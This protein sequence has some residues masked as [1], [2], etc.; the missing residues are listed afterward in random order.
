MPETVIELDPTPVWS[1][2]AM[3]RAIDRL[4]EIG[5]AA[6]MPAKHLVADLARL[7]T[8]IEEAK[9]KLRACLADW[10][11]KELRESGLWLWPDFAEPNDSPAV[12]S[13][14]IRI[15][16][17]PHGYQIDCQA[18]Y[19]GEAAFGTECRDYGGN[20]ESIEEAVH[21]I[22]DAVRGLA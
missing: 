9:G 4:P 13:A 8:E 10:S 6:R 15:G 16:L 5:P 22:L 18:D 12:D 7:T 1:L 14:T 20:I 17:V 21:K 11:D 2:E 19:R 3:N